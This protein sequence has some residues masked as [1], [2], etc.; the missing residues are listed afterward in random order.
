MPRGP[1]VSGLGPKCAK[2]LGV[3]PL[4]K[5]RPARPV[6]VDD[7]EQP[8]LLDQLETNEKELID[9]E[10]TK[11]PRLLVTG[12]PVTSEQANE[13]L[14][15]TNNWWMACND[16]PWAELVY[17]LAG[18]EPGQHGMPALSAMNEFE[19]RAGVLDLHYLHNSRI[20]S[21]WIGGPHG[22]C[23]WDGRIGATNY[24]IGKWPDVDTVGEDW[25]AVAAAFPFLRLRAQLAPE[26][27]EKPP[28]VEWRVANGEA[29]MATEGFDPIAPD[30][31]SD[32]A[33]LARLMVRG[34]ERGVDEARLREALTQVLG[35]AR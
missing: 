9:M 24:N 7:P 13:I 15:R 26:E 31:L 11:W 22:W 2:R 12:D 8:S 33:V 23:D 27:G 3:E 4:R 29:V 25:R 32:A 1:V 10:L 30:Q 17:R 5:S 34:G 6:R 16:K 18:I 14:I 28:V 19:A 35:G 20:A 21:A